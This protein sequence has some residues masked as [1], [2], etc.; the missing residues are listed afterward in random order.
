MVIFVIEVLIVVAALPSR[1]VPVTLVIL[2]VILYLPSGRVSVLI[3]TVKLLTMKSS[4]VFAFSVMLL[5]LLTR[6]ILPDSI[7]VN[8]MVTFEMFVFIPAELFVGRKVKFK[9][10]VPL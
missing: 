5:E 3:R 1:G 6:N 7:W 9:K 10:K 4:P 2:I 8:Q